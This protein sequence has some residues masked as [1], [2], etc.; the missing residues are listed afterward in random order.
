MKRIA[1]IILLFCLCI[2]VFGE[3]PWMAAL[4]GYKPIYFITGIGEDQAKVRVSFK[5]DFFY[6][7]KIGFFF[8]Y[9]QLMFW[10]LY[11][12]SGPFTEIDFNFDLFWRFESGNNFANDYEIPFIDYFQAGL[13]EHT[14]NGMPGVEDTGGENLSRGID[15]IYLQFQ[16]GIGSW[17]RLCLNFKYFYCFFIVYNDEKHD[18]PDIQDY[19]GSF[20]CRPFLVFY[21]K[22]LNDT[23]ELYGEFAAG[24]G[25][26][27]LDFTEGGFLEIG[28]KSYKLLSCFRIYAQYYQGYCESILNYNKSAE[29]SYKNGDGE[30]VVVPFSFR[31]G[32]IIE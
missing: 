14:S 6:P 23:L 20:V 28:F 22:S 19:I 17:L 16:A 32:V 5:F 7:H 11:E 27:G 4:S 12:F 30:D 29:N 18:N 15:R 10:D 1:L 24:G 21:N 3:S 8:G 13:W 31:V 25:V 2:L 9:S 26:N